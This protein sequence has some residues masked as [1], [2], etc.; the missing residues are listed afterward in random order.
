M[1][2][3]EI[4]VGNDDQ[5]VRE[6][7]VVSMQRTASLLS[8]NA[9]QEFYLPL[10]KRQRKGDIFPMRI[11]ACFLYAD[12]YRLVNDEFK[13]KVRKKLTK[14]AKDD[15]PMVRRGAAQCISS[16]AGHLEI[17]HAREFLLPM[18][19]GLL[20]DSNDSVKINAVQS[21]VLVAKAVNDD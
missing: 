10:L 20:E 5:A 17:A 2:P 9:I 13:L 1:E 16:I 18:V 14:L 7:A 12:L 6:K 11:S 15:T 4:V 3:L 21:S 8:P 19:K